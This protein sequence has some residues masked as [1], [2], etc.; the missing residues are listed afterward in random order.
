MAGVKDAKTVSR[1]ASGEVGSMRQESEQRARAAYE[2]VQVLVRFDSPRIAKAWFV[3]LNP[4][5]DDVT[6]AEAIREGKLE[7]ATAAALAFVA[8]G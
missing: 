4:Q 5:L 1:W 2:V 7:E 6:P 8:D 3:G